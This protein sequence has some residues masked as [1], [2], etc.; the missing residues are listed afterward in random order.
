M[1]LNQS[2]AAK[3]A[4]SQRSVKIKKLR[5]TLIN[6][7]TDFDSR[8]E[9]TQTLVHFEDETYKD[10]KYETMISFDMFLGILESYFENTSSVL[11]L[12]ANHEFDTYFKQQDELLRQ[13]EDETF[14][15]FVKQ[16]EN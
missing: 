7:D 16:L 2:F 3:S 1:K 15:P 9:K 13:E 11:C 10:E 14:D 6:K 4:H 8:N 5:P 12:D